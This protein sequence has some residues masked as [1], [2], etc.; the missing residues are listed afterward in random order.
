MGGIVVEGVDTSHNKYLEELFPRIEAENRTC[1]VKTVVTTEETED[2]S[3]VDVTGEE[4][5]TSVSSPSSSSCPVLDSRAASEVPFSSHGSPATT[6]LSSV[7]NTPTRLLPGSRT[8]VDTNLSEVHRASPSTV[9]KA[10]RNLANHSNS[11]QAS[12][13]S[14]DKHCVQ[15]S[16]A[17]VPQTKPNAIPALPPPSPVTME[18]DAVPRDASLTSETDTPARVTPNDV[19]T[20]PTGDSAERVSPT[21]IPTTVTDKEAPPTEATSKSPAGLLTSTPNGVVQPTVDS[22]QSLWFS[23]MPRKPCE[24]LHFIH[25]QQQQTVMMAPQYVVQGGYAYVAA[26]GAL[27]NQPVVQQIPA[28]YALMGGGLMPQTQYVINPGPMAINGQQYVSVGGQPLALTAATP[29]G[30]GA[31]VQ[32]V[33]IGGTQY[34]VIQPPQANGEEGQTAENSTE[35]KEKEPNQTTET[36]PSPPPSDAQQPVTMDTDAQPEGYEAAQANATSS[37]GWFSS[38]VEVLCCS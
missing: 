25:G 26:G 8:D 20:V 1:N 28:G 14:Q 18:A 34:A 19:G 11:E 17:A 21:L 10:V 27:V 36:S 35:Q 3:K 31:G 15:S 32:Y 38:I 12:A 9:S 24:M 13:S 16:P 5:A 22:S 23:V 7:E 2:D 37:P 33:N 4:I 6:V 29:G 30:S